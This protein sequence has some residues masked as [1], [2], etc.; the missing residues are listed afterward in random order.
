LPAPP[1]RTR[2]CRSWSRWETICSGSTSRAL[3]SPTRASRSGQDA[4]PGASRPAGTAVGDDGVKA[5]AGSSI[6]ETLSLYGT[7]VTDAG[8]D[9]SGNRVFAT[10]LRRGTKV[11]AP[12]VE[13][14]PQGPQGLARH[15]KFFAHSPLRGLS[16]RS[17]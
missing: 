3:A 1:S 2:S 13:A 8:L 16:F 15:A 12:A 5:L 17:P 6:L 4:E 7:G 9:T 14:T 10:A 11:T